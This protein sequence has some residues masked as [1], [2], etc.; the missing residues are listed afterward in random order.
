MTD[1][2]NEQNAQAPVTPAQDSSATTPVT[3]PVTTQPTAEQ[4]VTENPETQTVEPT[5]SN[6]PAPVAEADSTTSTPESAQP[7]PTDQPNQEGAND[8]EKKE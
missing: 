4:P 8:T 1:T 7:T 2:Q 3:E 6:N 5:S